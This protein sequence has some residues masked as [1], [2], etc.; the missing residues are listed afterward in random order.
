MMGLNMVE[1]HPVNGQRMISEWGMIFPQN[2]W[3]GHQ[4]GH[5][6][7]WKDLGNVIFNSKKKLGLFV[8]LY[9]FLISPNLLKCFFCP[10]KCPLIISNKDVQG[11]RSKDL[12]WSWIHGGKNPILSLGRSWHPWHPWLLRDGAPYRGPTASQGFCPRSSTLQFLGW[13]VGVEKQFWEVFRC[14]SKKKK[15]SNQ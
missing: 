4:E 7:R 14:F 8:N 5:R 6:K 1:N 3:V 10:Q 13:M 15:M 2:H 12:V 11:E 9:S